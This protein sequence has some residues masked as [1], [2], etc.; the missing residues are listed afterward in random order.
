M[1]IVLLK[2]DENTMTPDIFNV[3]NSKCPKTFL[4]TL[5]SIEVQMALW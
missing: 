4:G 3:T 1:D 5:Y 2:L